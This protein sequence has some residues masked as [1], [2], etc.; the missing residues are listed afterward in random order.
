MRTLIIK[1]VIHFPLDHE[2]TNGVED[3]VASKELERHDEFIEARVRTAY[4]TVPIRKKS[5]GRK[6]FGCPAM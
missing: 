2:D 6:I 3:L 1:P 4:V 5:T